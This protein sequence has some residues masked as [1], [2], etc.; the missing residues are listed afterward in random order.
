MAAEIPSFI[1]DGKNNLGGLPLP[2]RG[3]SMFESAR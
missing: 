3:S 1:A 2:T